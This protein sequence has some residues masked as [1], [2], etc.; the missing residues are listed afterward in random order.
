[1][2]VVCMAFAA[3]AASDSPFL[4]SQP[5]VTA[6]DVVDMSERA[7]TIALDGTADM[8]STTTRGCSSFEVGFQPNMSL[9]LE[10]VGDTP[11]IDPWVVVNGKRDW[12]N[13][14]TLLTEATAGARDDQEK[15]LLLYEFIR[16]NR[17]HDSPL[18]VHDEL[19]DPVKHFNSYGAGLCDDISSVTCAMAYAAGFTQDRHGADPI[20]RAMH[21][22]VMSEVAVDGQH[23][24]I[25]TDENAFYLDLSNA[26]P[27]SGDAIMRDSYLA[28]REH[29]YGPLF[30]GWGLG[31]RAAALLGRDDGQY[32]SITLGHEMHLT[33]RPGEKLTYRWDNVGKCPGE[34]TLKFFA[35]SF[36]DYAPPLVT[37][38]EAW[39]HSSNALS[40]TR[41]GL[42]GAGA[43]SWVVIKVESPYAICGGEVS[44]DFSDAGGA[45]DVSRDPEQWQKLWSEGTECAVE[46]DEALGVKTDKPC[47]KYFVRVRLGPATLRK[48]HIRTVLLTSPHALPR[49]SLGKNVVRYTDA[50]TE[51]HQLRITHT[52]RES[53]NIAPP[54]APGLVYPAAGAV[55]RDSTPGFRWEAVEGA[56]KYN[57]RVS[58]R[59]DMKTSYRPALDVTVSPNEHSSPFTGLLNPDETYYWRVRARNAAGLWG[60]WSRTQGFSWE[61]P[62]PPVEVALEERGDGLTLTWGPNPRGTRPVRYEVH[63]CN[64]RGFRPSRDPHEVHTLGEVLPTLLAEL[65][66]IWLP[67]VGSEPGLP[68]L[69]SYRVIA[70]DELGTRSGPSAV[71]EIPC[72]RIFTAPVTEATAGEE[73]AYAA[74][75]LRCEGDLQYRYQK[76]GYGYWER[77]GSEFELVEG[78]QWL[79]I[80]AGAGLLSGTPGAGDVGQARV[81]VKVRRTWPDEVKPDQHRPEYFVK[82]GPEFQAED[83]Q[84]FVVTVAER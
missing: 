60:D 58:R 80:D 10:N 19:H 43:D 7:Y 67:V 37:G 31:E 72:P 13:I 17:Y 59:P 61:G 73:Y 66:A 28:I 57:L 2:M 36:L 3:A 45:V 55:V 41:E 63:G 23:Q 56:T 15:L 75:T 34:G 53:S 78:P 74:R 33:L 29:A 22:H 32:R 27:V 81:V 51:P 76:P 5:K 18:F 39:A 65:S 24:F 77:E 9:V 16:R 64:R 82:D 42:V 1:M 35:N 52:Y 46:V 4:A 47:Y 54:A 21:G 70:V 44:A 79:S 48:L 40:A 71:V 50:T 68:N 38:P 30:S 6:V 20:N 8:D 12:R 62:M 84:S 26:R 14:D 83:T 25:D 69:S 49:L 11:V